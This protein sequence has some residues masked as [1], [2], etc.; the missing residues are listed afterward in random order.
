MIPLRLSVRNFM[1]YRDN[2]PTLD[3]E[4]LHVACLCGDN[5]HGKSALLDAITWALWGSARASQQHELIHQGQTDMEVTLDILVRD[6]VY[7]VIRKHTRRAGAR[8]GATVLEFQASTGDGFRP[9]TANSV[10]DTEALI[11]RT[12]Q[13]DYDTF[14]NTA[15]LQQGKADQFTQNTA[16]KR[17][18]FL[19]EALGLSYYEQLEERAKARV[20][21]LR[22]SIRDAEERIASRQPEID[23]KPEYEGRLESA[24]AS[25]AALVPERDE[26]RAEY[27]ALQRTATELSL[28]RRD[29][30]DMENRLAYVRSEAERLERE[31]R[32]LRA[33]LDA[34]EA[35][36]ARADEIE[37][38][39]ATLMEARTELEKLNA[40]QSSL[41]V[42][43]VQESDL[44][45]K[46]DGQRLELE[47][48]HNRL[49][50][51]VCRLQADAD[52]ISQIEEHLRLNDIA[53]QRL[54]QSALELQTLR[55]DERGHALRVQSLTQD[56]ERLRG[57]MEDTRRKFDLLEQGE[58]LCPLCNQ[59]VGE[60]GAEHLRAEYETQGRA[61][62][63]LYRSNDAE[64]R[65][66]D[67]KLNRMADRIAEMEREQD[68][69][70]RRIQGTDATLKRERDEA[71]RAR[72]QLGTIAP[73][74]ER[75]RA[76]L[77]S[78]DYALEERA[79][80]AEVAAGI[81]A[82]AYDDAGHQT[83]RDKVS[84][85]ESYE[86]LHRQLREA[87]GRLE[88]ERA[89]LDERQKTLA[90]RAAEA[91]DYEARVSATHD[92]LSALPEVEAKLGESE[93]RL[94]ELESRIQECEVQRGIQQDRI[95]HC[96]ALEELTREDESARRGLVDEKGIYDELAVA[97]GKNGIPAL[98]IENAIPEL[99]GDANR[100]LSRLTENRMSLKL[101]LKEGRRL[102]GSDV[103]A[104]ELDILIA[105]EIGTRSY[106]MFSGG[107]AFRIDFALRI[108]LSR[109]LASRSGAP[110]PIL[111]IDEGFGSQDASGQERLTEAIKSIEDD[112]QKIIVI[113]HVEQM[114]EAFPVRIEVT[115]EEYGSTFSIV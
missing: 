78:R 35:I 69:E 79:S 99:Q 37:A 92:E 6:Q 17:K 107:E 71:E 16:S 65:E 111:F 43:R 10:R 52:R 27:E 102:R 7:R 82:L 39:Y 105:D 33:R 34:D 51:D 108:A 68:V 80:L 114:K 98:I 73:Q 18:E 112:F 94:R 83:Q 38:N 63:Q 66:L 89:S 77:E 113:T 46:I 74:L 36:A 104:E 85:F 61:A 110:L 91:E 42:L 29:L 26:R 30:P 41:N 109:L 21:E 54:A 13:L 56:N 87:Q 103:R 76:R 62:G 22:D 60:N 90:R 86:E 19:A 20:A 75:L 100:L 58:T 96:E 53:Q 11:V 45:H 44:K 55:D 93:R 15:Y 49:D 25:I 50:D 97:F 67:S 31:T 84:A 59:E 9:I 48:R 28:K 88:S 101:E 40:A 1:C 5:G 95:A 14:I 106:E 72:E 47:Y 115:K 2:V 81:E 4:G 64:K 12:I 70:G 8:Q 23:R 3:F 24:L 32:E 57:E